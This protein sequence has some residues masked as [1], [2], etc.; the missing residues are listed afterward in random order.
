M[1]PK[2]IK[3]YR[4]TRLLT[5]CSFQSLIFNHLLEAKGA[6]DGVLLFT[7]ECLAFTQDTP[8]KAVCPFLYRCLSIT[9]CST[10]LM[11]ETVQRFQS[12]SSLAQKSQMLG[13]Y[14]EIGNKQNKRL[15]TLGPLLERTHAHTDRWERVTPLN[16]RL[17]LPFKIKQICTDTSNLGPWLCWVIIWDD[18]CYE[19]ITYDVILFAPCIKHENIMRLI[20]NFSNV[21]NKA[22]N[23]DHSI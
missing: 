3:N 1:F 22:R 4:R 20:M 15:L 17:P 8:C 18:R 19:T 5:H 7:V 11:A 23:N 12:K 21:C 13:Y 16:S 10:L 14:S 9:G 2:S 6:G